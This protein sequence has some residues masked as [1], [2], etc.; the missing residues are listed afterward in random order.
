MKYKIEYLI[1]DYDRPDEA[2]RLLNSIKTHSKFEY[3]LTYLDNGSSEKYSK[4]FKD[5]GLI[6]NLIINEINSGCGAGTIQLFA[7]SFAD[8]AIYVQVDHM[9]HVDIDE[10]LICA[11]ASFIEEKGYS[12]VDLAGNQGHGRYSERAQF[13]SPAFYNSIPKS[14]GGPGPWS[15][16]KWTEECVQEFMKSNDC[17]FKSIYNYR[18]YGDLPIFLDCGKWSVRQDKFGVIW[19]HRTD[20]KEV[21]SISGE[22]NQEY[23]YYPFSKEQWYQILKD[24]KCYNMVPEGWKN[25]VF[26]CW[27]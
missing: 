1:L 3:K 25:S 2:E 23:S 8:Y 13:I 21:N 9:L 15:D 17:K 11:M 26:K 12:Y 5:K 18:E 4:A 6:D 19:R 10:K 24:K 27:D 22:V 7:Q 14:I 20:T 16:I